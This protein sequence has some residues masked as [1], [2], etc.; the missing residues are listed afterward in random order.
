MPDANTFVLP[1]P[2]DL[3]AFF[4]VDRSYTKRLK[5]IRHSAQGDNKWPKD[6][7]EFLKKIW[8]IDPKIEFYFMPAATFM[9]DDPRIHK[10]RV[11]ELPV[12]EF[13]KLGNCFIY[14]LPDGYSDAGPRV[15]LEAQAES[16]AVIADNRYGAKDRVTESTGWLCSSHDDYMRTIRDIVEVPSLLRTKGQA[17]RKWAKKMYAPHRWIEEILK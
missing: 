1:P 9:M 12:P 5:L 11:N 17:A 14:N 7:N 15:I 8:A 10:Y 13:L 3:T 4:N 16:L 2:T 6:I